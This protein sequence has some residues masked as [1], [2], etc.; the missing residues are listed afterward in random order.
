MLTRITNTAHANP[1]QIILK[2]Q[3]LFYSSCFGMQ[4]SGKLVLFNY[5]TIAYVFPSPK[6]QIVKAQNVLVLHSHACKHLHSI[7]LITQKSLCVWHFIS[8]DWNCILNDAWHKSFHPFLVD[9][10]RGHSPSMTCVLA[11]TLLHLTDTFL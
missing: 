7:N 9:R 11:S 1:P 10:F 2:K 8:A 4:L 5:Y 6:R 3:D